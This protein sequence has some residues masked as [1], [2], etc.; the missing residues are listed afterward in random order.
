LKTSKSRP[1]T[2]PVTMEDLPEDQ[3]WSEAMSRQQEEDVAKE[4]ARLQEVAAKKKQQEQD[5]QNLLQLNTTFEVASSM[6]GLDSEVN[7]ASAAAKEAKWLSSTSKRQKAQYSLD[8]LRAR[9]LSKSLEL[10]AESDAEVSSE[11]EAVASRQMFGAPAWEAAAG[12]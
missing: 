4:S 9:N 5:A 10:T 3:D 11:L 2:P 1:P 6:G 7:A 8:K 12:G